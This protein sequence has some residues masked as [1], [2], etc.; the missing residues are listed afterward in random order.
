MSL[1]LSTVF[2]AGFALSGTPIFELISYKLEDFQPKKCLEREYEWKGQARI[3]KCLYY[4][5]QVSYTE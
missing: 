5:N 1:I 2:A 4:L 3:S